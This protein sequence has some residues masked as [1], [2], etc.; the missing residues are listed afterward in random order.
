MKRAWLILLLAVVSGC[1]DREPPEHREMQAMAEKIRKYVEG[2]LA[3]DGPSH[4][5]LWAVNASCFFAREM[6]CVAGKPPDTRRGEPD[7]VRV[8]EHQAFKSR[9]RC[10]LLKPDG[11]VDAM[12]A[13]GYVEV[14]TWMLT[15]QDLRRLTEIRK[16]FGYWEKLKTALP[17]SG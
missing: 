7:K 8:E 12:S 13:E 10:T 5:I 14:L 9:M 6:D 11:L 1:G 3:K 15:K 4:D 17:P 16:K 2:E